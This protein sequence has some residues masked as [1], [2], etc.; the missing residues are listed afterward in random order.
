MAFNC[1]WAFS[2]DAELLAEAR[3]AARLKPQPHFLTQAGRKARAADRGR[4]APEAAANHD[5]AVSRIPCYGR[6]L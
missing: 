6:T 4:M 3:I 2:P 5:T 1:V